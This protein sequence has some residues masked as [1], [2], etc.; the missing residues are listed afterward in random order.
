MRKRTRILLAAAVL[1]TSLLW[2]GDASEKGGSG[3]ARASQPALG[4][5]GDGAGMANPAAVYC[6]ELGY[7]YSVFDAEQGQHGICAFPDGTECDEWSFLEGRCGQGHS[8]CA[9]QGY[10]LIVKT[11]GR[12]PFSSEYSV[13][14][15][16]QQEIGPATELMGLREKASRAALAPEQEL[17]RPQGEVSQEDLPASFDW[18]NHNGHDWMTSVRDQANCGSCWAFSAV[19]A[20]EAAYNIATQNPGLDLNLSE[21]YLVSDCLPDN[22]C[23]GGWHDVALQFVKD[24]G[25]PDES[26]MPYADST[27]TCPS[28]ICSSANCTYYAANSC[29]NRT[30]S[31]RCADWQARLKSIVETGAVPSD[32]A[33]I[34]Q[35]AVDEG[36][37]AVAL[38]M[39][40]TFD[41]GIY[42]CASP[43]ELNHAV[44]IAGYNDV[45]GY[46]IVKN[47]WGASWNGDGYFNVGYGECLIETAV[48]YA[49]APGAVPGA[50]GGM[51]DFPDIDG[52]APRT[53]DS[54]GASSGPPYAAVAAGVAGV[55]AIAAGGWYARRRLS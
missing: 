36:P 28:D 9:K 14:V 23:C 16:D 50:V 31:D 40:G 52:S 8:Y 53:A 7:E 1:A 42:R 47:S 43:D 45:G 48:F 10:D 25:I 29:S 21:E 18:R 55:L 33:T 15:L 22:T 35:Y 46:W 5:D 27:C 19:G 24:T 37:L 38:D 26:C 6:Y 54:S 49:E 51:A 2:L 30:C 11:D 34:K 39:D 44:V 12:N 13:C 20:V 17:S 41:N 32:Q 4:C 3:V